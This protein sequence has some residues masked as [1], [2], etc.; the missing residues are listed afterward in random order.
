MRNATPPTYQITATCNAHRK[1]GEI[2][3]V[4]FEI[5][6]WT[7]CQ[8]DRYAL[9]STPIVATPCSLLYRETSN[10]RVRRSRVEDRG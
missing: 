3:I 10:I 4:V 9:H 7:D 1:F 8:T 2:L 5:C 6:E